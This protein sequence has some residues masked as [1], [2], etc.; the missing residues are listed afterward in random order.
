MLPAASERLQGARTLAGP[1]V[2]VARLFLQ[3][4]FDDRSQSRGKLWRKRWERLAKDSGSQLESRLATERAIAVDISKRVTAE[5]P[6][7]AARASLFTAENF[8]RDVG[9]RADDRV[10]IGG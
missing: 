5:R 7:I 9:Q 2:A 8:G 3:A 10:G 4:T 6:D 1:L